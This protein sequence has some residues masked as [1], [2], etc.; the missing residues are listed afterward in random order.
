[1]ARQNHNSAPQSATEQSIREQKFVPEMTGAWPLLGHLPEFVKNPVAMLKRGWREQGDLMQFRLGPKKFVLFTGPEAHDFYFRRSEE[2]L[3]AKVVY[4]FT[5]PIFG[6]GVAYDV[7]PEIFSEQLRFLFPA[8]RDASMRRYARLMYKEAS[9]FADE[10]GDSGEIDLLH[11]LNELTVR[12][13][14]RCLI[15]EDV[16]KRVDTGF[17]EAYHELQSGINTLG[18]FM[19]RLPIKPHR[20]R[21]K[22]RKQ[23]VEIFS[24]AM[25]ERRRSGIQYDDFMQSLMNAHYK[26][27]RAL[28]DDEIIGILLTVLFAGQHTSSVLATWTCLELVNSQPYLA[29]VREEMQE[30]YRECREMDLDTLKKQV[31]LEHAIRENE[32]MH[33]PLIILFRKVLRTLHYRGYTIPAGTLAMVSPAVAHRVPHLFAAPDEFSPERFAP[34][35]SEDKQHHYSLIGFGGGKHM[36]MGKS[37]AYMQLKAIWTVL[38][39]RFEFQ[40]DGEVPAPNYGNW[41]TGPQLPCRVRYSR[42]SQPSLFQ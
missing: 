11:Q 13:A 40:L 28:N 41:V 15:G 12:I 18:F 1:M 9:Q 4:Q 6:R 26:N 10:L 35:A 17:A 22:A 2:E 31:A 42:R 25:A 36:C 7:S 21:D 38:L 14:S 27:G 39:D 19:P 30:V 20:R 16:R 24:S 3:N 29:R 5:V 23:L 37:F 34:P 32:R 8:L 33:P